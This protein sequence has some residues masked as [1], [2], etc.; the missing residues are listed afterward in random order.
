MNVSSCRYG[1]PVFAS[2]PHFNRA[3]SSLRDKVIGLN[4]D[5][6]KHDF[7]ITLEPTT[8]IPLK[9]QARLQVNVL[10]EPSKTVSLFN[11]VPTI[12]FPVMWFSLDVETADMFMDDL[13]TLLS[14]SDVFKYIGA[15]LVIVGSLTIFIV[16]LLYLLSRQQANSVANDKASK[17]RMIASTGNKTEL[18]YLDTSGAADDGHVRNDRKLYPIPVAP[19]ECKSNAGDRLPTDDQCFDEADPRR[20][21]KT[22]RSLSAASLVRS[23]DL[24]FLRLDDQFRIL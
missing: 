4:P 5:D 9:V 2:L 16:A 11:D 22:G 15:I 3:D 24:V 13:K 18:M 8:G 10:L 14:L 21:L 19:I 1:A 12:Y 17:P 6:E 7:A 20:D 23:Q